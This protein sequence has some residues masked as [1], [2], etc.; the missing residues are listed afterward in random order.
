MTYGQAIS[1]LDLPTPA[2]KKCTGSTSNARLDCR[3]H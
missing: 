2:T 3:L 1:Q